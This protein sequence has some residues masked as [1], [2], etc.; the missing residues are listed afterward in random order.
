MENLLCV[1]HLDTPIPVS[2]AAGCGG[3]F[4]KPTGRLF[5]VDGASYVLGSFYRLLFAFSFSLQHTSATLRQRQF[6]EYLPCALP[7]L[8][9]D[10]RRGTSSSVRGAQL[11]GE[12]QGSFVQP[13]GRVAARLR[14]GEQR[15]CRSG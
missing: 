9:N 12:L 14:L 3:F 15:G 8:P 11:L 2:E 1:E 13:G 7:L 10:S 5:S 6:V 4:Q